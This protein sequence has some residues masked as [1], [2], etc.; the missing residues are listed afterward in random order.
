M[1]DRGNEKELVSVIIPTY[2]R[3]ELLKRSVESVMAQTYENWEL[4]VIDDCS[5][6]GIYVSYDFYVAAY[7]YADA[8]YEIVSRQ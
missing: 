6:D 1:S 4:I 7:R 8:A 2:N 5:D 3:L